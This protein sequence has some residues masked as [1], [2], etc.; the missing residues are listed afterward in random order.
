M[1]GGLLIGLVEAY[2]GG[3]VSGAYKDVSVFAVL[4]LVLTVRPT[5]LFGRPHLE[6]V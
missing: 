1:I 5:G 4:I 2:W 6:K 3:Y